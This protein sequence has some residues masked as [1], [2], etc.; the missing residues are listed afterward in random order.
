MPFGLNGLLSRPG[1]SAR[2]CEMVPIFGGHPGLAHF[3][4]WI[5]SG[6]ASP[7]PSCWGDA[8]ARETGNLERGVHVR[9]CNGIRVVARVD[10]R[11][12]LGACGGG[13]GKRRHG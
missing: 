9:P 4:Y 11:G 1:G 10:A 13:A 5:L 6:T 7:Y 3:D 8:P 2:T 12:A